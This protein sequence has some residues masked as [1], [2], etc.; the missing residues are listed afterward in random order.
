[1]LK[2]SLLF[3]VIACS[4]ALGSQAQT[5]QQGVSIPPEMRQ[6][7]NDAYMKQ[8]WN[9]AAEAYAKI[10]K[11]DDSNV[12]AHYRFGLAMLNL[13]KPESALPHLEKAFS[14][15]PNAVFALALARTYARI[16]NNTKTY[17]I[18]DKSVK[19]GGIAGETLAA[20]RDFDKIRSEQQ[21]KDFAVRSDITAN[22]CK[23]S[24]EF[25]Q[26]DFWIGEWDA[27][28]AQGV[29]VGSSSIQLILGSCVIFENW[30]TPVVSGK[31]L[32]IYD[33]NDKKWHQFWFDNKGTRTAYVGELQD[34]KMVYVADISVG[35]K[36]AL[37]KM[38]FSKLPNGDVR[39]L[40]ENSTDNG[41]TW[42]PSFD[43]TYV[44]KN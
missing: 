42:K 2:R 38:T 24:P 12:P 27:K 17:E 5:P 25:R 41:K 6:E 21:F 10:L 36:K 30:N 39:Q 28:N 40:G 3:V 4:V 11:L 20:E 43:F 31:S 26:F 7:A 1:M 14:T 13:N 8:D 32:N 23:A 18:L 16:G 44:R 33:T 19:L 37:A 22:P 15:S 35:G 9:G 34:G 29:T